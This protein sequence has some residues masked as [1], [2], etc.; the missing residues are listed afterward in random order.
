MLELLQRQTAHRK[1]ETQS[2]GFLDKL[3]R[4]KFTWDE[5]IDSRTLGIY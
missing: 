2:V 3:M 1:S 5:N 4:K